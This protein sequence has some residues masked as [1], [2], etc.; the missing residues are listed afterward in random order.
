M[1]GHTEQVLAWCAVVIAVAG[2][3]FL[4]FACVHYST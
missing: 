4:I 1:T 3:A 2:V